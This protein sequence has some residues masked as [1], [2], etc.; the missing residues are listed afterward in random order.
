MTLLDL[1]HDKLIVVVRLEVRR[2]RV[3]GQILH[4]GEEFVEAGQ[5]EKHKAG[6]HVPADPGLDQ[7][8]GRLE[9]VQ[10]WHQSV[11]IVQEDHV[12]VRIQNG[13]G[14]VGEELVRVQSKEG[15]NAQARWQIALTQTGVPIQSAVASDRW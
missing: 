6:A 7:A 15:A 8:V 10:Q 12:V 3:V 9:L 14:S 4:N 5:I 2:E 11:E 1:Q 13:T